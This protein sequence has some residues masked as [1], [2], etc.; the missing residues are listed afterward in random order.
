VY[1]GRKV[2]TVKKHKLMKAVCDA[3]KAEVQAWAYNMQ[4]TY[5]EIKAQ[6]GR[7]YSYGVGKDLEFT[8][9]VNQLF[10]CKDRY[11]KLKQG[12]ILLKTLQRRREDGM[13]ESEGRSFIRDILR[14]GADQRIWDR[15]K[16]DDWMDIEKVLAVW[17]EETETARDYEV[18][19]AEAKVLKAARK[20]KNEKGKG[21]KDKD[22]TDKKGRSGC[23]NCGKDGHIAA[24]CPEEKKP[25]N[26]KCY[27]CGKEG[28]VKSDCKTPVPNKATVKVYS[29]R[30]ELCL[31]GNNQW[32]PV[33]QCT[34]EGVEREALVDTGAGM[35]FWP[36]AD[37]DRKELPEKM[38]T[39]A[40]TD[41]KCKGPQKVDCWINGKRH[42]T[43]M[44]WNEKWSILGQPFIQKYGVCIDPDKKEVVVRRHEQEDVEE[45]SEGKKQL[46]QVVEQFEEAMVG[47]GKTTLV[48]HRIPTEEGRRV[49]RRNYRIP[50]ELEN[51][52]QEHVDELL[53]EGVI[54]EC[55]TNWC[56]PVLPL[57]KKDGSMRLAIDYREVNAITTDDMTPI[58]RIDEILDELCRAKIYS[59]LDLTKG[60]YQVPMAEEDKD[61]TAFVF[62]GKMY[63]FIRMP[64]GLKTA[65][66]TFQRLM[67]TV[68][69]GLPFVRC[70]LDDVVIFSE[71]VGKH[72]EHLRVVLERISKAGLRLNKKKCEFGIE[73]MDFLG[74]HVADGQFGPTEDKLKIVERYPVPT[75]SK[76]LGRFLG[77]A[78]YLRRFVKDFSLIAE[79]LN[80]ARNAKEFV[81][82]VKEGKA[83]EDLKSGIAKSEFVYLA[84]D[85]KDFVVTT[86]ASDI[87]MGGALFQVVNGEKRL[88]EFFSQSFNKT[89]RRYA[90]IEKEATAIIAALRKWRYYLFGASIIV[91]TDH[92]PLIW[93]LSKKDLE[94]KLGRMAY[95]LSEYNIKGIEHIK[96]EDNVLA[97]ALS[98]LDLAM[99]GEWDDAEHNRRLEELVIKDP[100]KFIKKPAGK[101]FLVEKDRSRLCLH[102]KEDINKVLVSLHDN[103]GHLGYEKVQAGSGLTG[104]VI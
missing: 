78:N 66:Q 94:N 95:E 57:E 97:D 34:V 62:R 64:F 93:L 18:L 2:D 17:E 52:I 33:L 87:G 11:S 59:R 76:E 90:T 29:K 98:R 65:P 51:K 10:D 16:G 36:C 74:Y 28:H 85:S 70:Y 27:R 45:S 32:R 80:K 73:S 103:A 7:K 24:F 8:E 56:S 50:R 21:E 81:W 99:L 67:N 92:K 46:E 22:G 53:K 72:S 48:E 58:P 42:E 6:L 96:G 5:E 88:I 83:F 49:N 20:D 84:G 23:F 4:W 37:L 71:S 9:S 60:Y 1:H 91:E 104:E 89:Q 13:T 15:L 31:V 61:K 12:Y 40:S 101:I 54:E 86:D 43:E 44:Y 68:V 69:D 35:N 38:I 82:T 19:I 77:F 41:L 79:P 14:N 102:R 63:R 75:N 47:I 26:V 39:T 25:F 100:Q 55:S 30:A 3:D